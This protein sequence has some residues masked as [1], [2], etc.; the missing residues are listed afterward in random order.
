MCLSHDGEA[1]NRVH[2]QDGIS[3]SDLWRAEPLLH[4]I[5]HSVCMYDIQHGTAYLYCGGTSMSLVHKEEEHSSKP[6]AAIL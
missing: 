1:G 2:G 4:Q 5:S 6:S 3:W